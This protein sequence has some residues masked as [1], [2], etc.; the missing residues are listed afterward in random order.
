[1]KHLPAEVAP[2]DTQGDYNVDGEA[3]D[4]KGVPA[5]PG[6]T[7]KFS[8]EGRNIAASQKWPREIYQDINATVNPSATGS[9]FTTR[10]GF[11]RQT[12]KILTTLM[13]YV[14]NNPPPRCALALPKVLDQNDEVMKI[15]F[16]MT[17]TYTCELEFE[18]NDNSPMYVTSY[19]T[20]PSTGLMRSAANP[21]RNTFSWSSTPQNTRAYIDSSNTDPKSAEL[22][23]SL[24]Q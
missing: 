21:F 15:G 16:H 24:V 18:K 10:Q 6:Q 8:F 7:N 9:Q 3:K 13:P 22:F 19:G 23:P 11:P 20:L 5:T 4:V 17:I 14:N 1:M 2:W 12:G